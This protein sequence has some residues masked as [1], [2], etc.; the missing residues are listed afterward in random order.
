MEM[1]PRLPPNF[2]ILEQ[3]GPGSRVFKAWDKEFQRLV[4]IKAL[5]P[6]PGREGIVEPG[7]FFREARATAVCNH[8]NIPRMLSLGEFQSQVYYAREFVEGETL[9]SLISKKLFSHHEAAKI[10][11][12]VADA[13]HHVHSRGMIHGSLNLRNVILSVD[14]APK[15]IDFERARALLSEPGDFLT[16]IEALEGCSF[17]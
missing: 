13:V 8:P 3:L 5:L 9:Q 7:R 15:L 11:A 6:K 1:L 4:A 2:E 16:D 12:A 10:V 14:G 17:P